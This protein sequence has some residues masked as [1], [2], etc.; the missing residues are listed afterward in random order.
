MLTLWDFISARVGQPDVDSKVKQRQITPI[1][2]PDRLPVITLLR[3][4]SLPPH[5]IVCAGSLAE[6]PASFSFSEVV[7]LPALW[8]TA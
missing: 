6:K 2:M 7:T 5:T 8:D 1:A 3:D 4:G